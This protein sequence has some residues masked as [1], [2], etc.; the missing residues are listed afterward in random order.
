MTTSFLGLRQGDIIL[1]VAYNATTGQEVNRIGHLAQ[2]WHCQ[3]PE[4]R[5]S[6]GFK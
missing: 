6:A 3:A 5:G 1:F 4:V 2:V